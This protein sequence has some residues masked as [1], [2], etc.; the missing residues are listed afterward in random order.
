[1]QLSSCSKSRYLLY[2]W[3]S[4]PIRPYCT[5]MPPSRRQKRLLLILVLLVG[6]A[7]VTM[8]LVDILEA[9]DKAEEAAAP[10][11]TE[12]VTVCDLC[13]T[14]DTSNK[15]QSAILGSVHFSLAGL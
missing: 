11:K 8:R 13:T 9:E 1:M 14:V 6:V 2:A 5:T 7:A 12:G 10:G 3:N 4:A 15:C